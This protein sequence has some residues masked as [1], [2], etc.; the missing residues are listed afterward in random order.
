[1]D[2]LNGILSKENCLVEMAKFD[3]KKF[4]YDYYNEYLRENT[5]A[6]KNKQIILEKCPYRGELANKDSGIEQFL[7]YR[8][9][10]EILE[11]KVRL[12]DCD[13]SNDTCDVTTALY[14]ILWNYSKNSKESLWEN[15][16]SGESKNLWK[17]TNK[18][19][20]EENLDTYTSFGGDTMNS[21]LTTYNFCKDSI[22][23][24]SELKSGLE[25]LA[26]L[27]HTIGN[28]VLVPY[29]FNKARYGST[30][31]YWDASLDIL[32]KEGFIA[33]SGK[34][35]EN[36]NWVKY[37]NI[38]F[39]WDYIGENG[40]LLPLF[41]KGKRKFVDEQKYGMLTSLD[42]AKDFLCT[43]NKAIYR[44]GIFMAGQ[45]CIALGISL[46]EHFRGN[47]SDKCINVTE[48]YKKMSSWLAENKF[49]SYEKYFGEIFKWLD[50]EKNNE[51]ID[52]KQE[53][54][55]VK[56]ILKAVYAEM[57]IDDVKIERECR[58]DICEYEVTK[59]AMTIYKMKYDCYKTSEVKEIGTTLSYYLRNK[60]QDYPKRNCRGACILINKSGALTADTL[61][62]IKSPINTLVETKY[63]KETGE[64][65]QSYILQNRCTYKKEY[66]QDVTNAVKAFAYVYRWCGNMMPV[67]CNYSMGSPDKVIGDN[68]K[69]KINLILN[70]TINKSQ[71]CYED[72][73][74]NYNVFLAGKGSGYWKQNKLWPGWLKETEY[75]YFIAQNYLEDFIDRNG[76]QICT[77][78]ICKKADIENFRDI[79]QDAKNVKKW[80]LVNTKLIIQRSYRIQ[81]Q[82]SKDW[83]DS[84]KDE[85]NAKSIMRYVFKQAG[86]NEKEIEAE[87]L[88]TIF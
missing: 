14:K 33:R 16:D 44:R 65:I 9:A 58:D 17:W 30:R 19:N 29:G 38:F 25:K 34:H 48:I 60:E 5:V 52:N 45:L 36:D 22:N 50:K 6:G 2:W 1:M 39:L 21:F 76:T 67:I 27:T 54:E 82:F 62:S 18:D 43:V 3:F 32:Q 8:T 51:K 42:D 85:E 86:F 37:I 70:I 56:A 88:S 59:K 7:A 72:E 11:K 23:E 55:R 77:K 87:N 13:S 68:W 64:D 31:D 49:S 75:D 81:Y 4:M 41:N 53:Y 35:F 69:N 73:V 78:D 12:F 15:T 20:K 66:T 10:D 28:F 46:D 61:T 63:G 57:F 79:Y 24:D 71:D 74:K 26:V 83:K 40:E 47:F 80:F 84:E